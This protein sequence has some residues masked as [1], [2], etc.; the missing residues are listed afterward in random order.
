VKEILGEPSWR[1]V[2]TDQI[3]VGLGLLTSQIKR[4]YKDIVD[5]EN[6]KTFTELV[7]AQTNMP[8]R[9]QDTR[10]E[11]PVHN[12][13]AEI[14]NKENTLGNDI[15]ECVQVMSADVRDD[16]SEHHD[17]LAEASCQRG[18]NIRCTI[19]WDCKSRK[20]SK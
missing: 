10:Q 6:E 14:R 11:S 7:H 12:D 13:Q 2:I 5:R 19:N 4:E 9:Q 15:E 20:F 18:Q 16:S 3:L 17:G 1:D 8:E